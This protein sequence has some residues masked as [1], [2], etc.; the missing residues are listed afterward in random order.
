M[1]EPD[2][3]RHREWPWKGG[4]AGDTEPQEQQFQ[5]SCFTPSK[6]SVRGEASAQGSQEHVCWCVVS[7]GAADGCALAVAS[8]AP[9]PQH[10]GSQQ[11]GTPSLLQLHGEKGLSN[12]LQCF[13]TSCGP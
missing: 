5:Q 3:G 11:H 12:S 6:R 13:S 1:K 8:F 4:R 9:G 7:I 10:R 2:V